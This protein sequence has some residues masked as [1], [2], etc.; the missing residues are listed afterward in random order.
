MHFKEQGIVRSDALVYEIPSDPKAYGSADQ[1]PI[2]DTGD[3]PGAPFFIRFAPDDKSLV[4][5]CTS[6]ST[7]KGEPYTAL[8]RYVRMC[9][10]MYV[11]GV[12]TCVCVCVKCGLEQIP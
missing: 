7:D 6:P 4:M 9:I 5:L 8:I 11:W 12:I 2:F 3:L 1:G 10:H